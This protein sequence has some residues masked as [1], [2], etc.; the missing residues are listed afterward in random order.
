MRYW[1]ILCNTFR[2]KS[3]Q[4]QECSEPREVL[5]EDTC[6]VGRGAAVHW[7]KS[8][9]DD[10]GSLTSSRTGV[11]GRIERMDV[12]GPFGSHPRASSAKHA[13]L[14]AEFICIRF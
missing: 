9:T 10:P 12:F 14:S 8:Q 6:T 1:R 2:R 7:T 11:S 13:K 5:W 4:P 3:E